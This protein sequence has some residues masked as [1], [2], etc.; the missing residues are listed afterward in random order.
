MT[1]AAN[2]PA[3][4]SSVEGLLLADKPAGVTSHD[5]ILAARRAYG[6]RSIGHLG[7]LDPFATG[8]LLLLFGRATRLA[9][10]I[11]T[12]PKVYEAEIRFGS[13]TATDDLTGEVVRTAELPDVDAVR[14][15][16]PELTGDLMQVPPAYSAKS[17]D[18]TR[19]Y[20]SARRG[21]MLELAPAPVHVESW[22]VNDLDPEFLR[23]TIT[24]GA[25]T[26]IRA[27]ARDLGRMTGS[28]A[29]LTSLRRTRSGEFD[30]HDAASL[31]D[32][33]NSPPPLRPL[34]VVA[35]NV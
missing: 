2:R 3:T 1:V 23:A 6:E 10:F 15:C 4:T 30:V 14:K 13:E 11:V 7:T 18:G 33:R 9:S 27:L 26:Y 5:V 16:L 21:E 8:L 34:S 24:C 35:G 28:A 19:A 25:G 17:V 12:E 32:L 22:K 31:E 29:H 20:D